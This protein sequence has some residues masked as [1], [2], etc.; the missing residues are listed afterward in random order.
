MHA[1]W[2]EYSGV[3]KKAL[4]LKGSPVAVT[5]SVE[6]VKDSAAG[7]H[8]VCNAFLGARD[9]KTID[10]TLSNSSCRGGSWHL[11]L[12]EPPTGEE[13]KALQEFLVKGEK[14]FC[15]VGS[16]YRAQKLSTAPPLGV[17]EHVVLSP[18][19]KAQFR[20]DLVLFVCNAEQGC[21]LVTLDM[22]STGIPPKVDMSGSTCHQAIAYP[23]VSG[24]LNVSLMDYTSRRIR[25]YDPGDLIVSIPYHRFHGVMRSIEYSTAG[26]AKMEIPESFRRQAGS[27]NLEELE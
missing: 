2:R 25:G 21:R 20:P 4:G 11:G 24:E 1:E 10:L 15:S 27:E 6:A 18:L 17:A 22:Y 9:G 5:Y 16:F 14:L 12:C 7:K 13:A 23:L 3:I 8:R 26:T 19:E